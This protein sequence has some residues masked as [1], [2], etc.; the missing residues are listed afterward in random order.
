MKTELFANGT[1]KITAENG[2]VLT[3]GGE[4]EQYPI[5]LYVSINDD[6]W[7][8]IEQEIEKANEDINE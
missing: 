7:Y 5:E 6:S 8:E 2:K 4:F 1:K 3:N